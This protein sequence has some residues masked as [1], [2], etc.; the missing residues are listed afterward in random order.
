MVC[1]CAV[2]P[3]GKSPITPRRCLQPY[4]QRQTSNAK[5]RNI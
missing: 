1:R 4:P 5:I 2:R 3:V